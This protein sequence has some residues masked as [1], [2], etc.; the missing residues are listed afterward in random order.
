[1]KNYTE[2]FGERKKQKYGLISNSI[3][4]LAKLKN[5][6]LSLPFFFIAMI[7]AS[8]IASI[9]SIYLPADVVAMLA[10]GESLEVIISFIVGTI[11]LIALLK[12]ITWLGQQKIATSVNLMQRIM[13][14]IIYK[15]LKIDFELLENPNTQK[16]INNGFV[17]SKR[18][19]HLYG[20][21]LGLYYCSQY[22]VTLTV[23]AIIVGNISRVILIIAVVNVVLGM[24]FLSIARKKHASFADK[25]QL[26]AK[27]AMYI[28]RIS[29]DSVVGKD[30][31]IFNLSGWLLKKYDACIKSMATVYLHI[32]D[33]YFG[34]KAGAEFTGILFDFYAYAF[35]IY[36]L[37][38]KKI[39]VSSFVLLLG[40]IRG[41]SSSLAAFMSKYSTLSPFS[42]A[43]SYIREALE[44]PDSMGWNDSIADEEIEKIKKEGITLII[45]NVSYTYPGFHTPTLQNINL[46]IHTGEKLALLGLN[47]A[48]K[49]TLVKLICGL[50]RPTSGEILIN[51]I[52]QNN[53]SYEKWQALIAVMFQDSVL[54]PWSIDANIVGNIKALK[55]SDEDKLKK[56]IELSGFKEKYD[57]LCKKGQTK[58]IREVNDDAV[59]F[60]GGEMQKMLFARALYKESPLIILDEPTSALDPVAEN[61]LYLNLAKSVS[62]KTMIYISHRLSSTRFCDRIVLLQNGRI[63]E[64]GTH[65]SL[66]NK[67]GTYRYLFDVQS[68]YYKKINEKKKR[69]EIF[70]DSFDEK[71]PQLLDGVF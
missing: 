66:M 51:N 50:Y 70:S 30:I 33:W 62:G 48:G 54:L 63:C 32:H 61:N 69:A 10:G 71:A 38:T 28:N 52:P 45:K 58:L 46:S 37:V 47:G 21:Y 9:V 44:E 13:G 27:Q 6:N 34:A 55:A 64:E 4:A 68:Q 57:S 24:Q 16:K 26:D 67:G 5:F 59:E 7:I 19:W 53:F 18:P 39:D 17:A 15:E 42:V 49:T 11:L 2:I 22:M 3:W 1:M 35:L 20:F 41:F 31:R 25:L 29:M 43:I 65:D 14:D 60:S 56:V 40:G 23:Y 8:P 12:T 36:M